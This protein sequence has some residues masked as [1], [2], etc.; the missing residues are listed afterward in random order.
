M[1]GGTLSAGFHPQLHAARPS[2]PLAGARPSRRAGRVANCQL[3]TANSKMSTLLIATDEAGYGPML[4]PL[5]VVATAWLLPD[6]C[7]AE[8]AIGALSAPLDLAG[9]GTVRVDDSKKVFKQSRGPHSTARPSIDWI[10]EA[11]AQWL[12]QP[13]PQADFTGWLQQTAAQDAAQLLATAWYKHEFP[14][15]EISV[16]TPLSEPLDTKRPVDAGE[17]HQR[18]IA[19][20]SSGGLRLVG[21]VARVLDAGPFN[22]WLDRVENKSNLL[23]EATCQLAVQ[24][25]Q[26]QAA[27]SLGAGEVNQVQI[28]SDRLGGRA[29][30]GGLLQHH[31]PSR[32]LQVISETPQQSSYR[33]ESDSAGVPPLVWHF[34]VSGDSFPPVAMSSVIAKSIRE[35]LM[36]RLNAFFRAAMVDRWPQAPQ[37]RPTAGYAV[38]A[39]RFLT[40]TERLRDQLGISDLELIRR[41]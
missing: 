14:A 13:D 29:Y 33:L 19:H 22:R 5:A 16:V 12:Q 24:L 4:G 6:D 40:D 31:L 26:A 21:Q 23:G 36:R 2:P 18:L 38:D 1:S 37:L 10:T 35:R 30:Y 27:G 17:I 20:W 15:A 32:M 11:A 8:A 28:H 41:K 3:P 39:R 25:L 9:L 7:D 34:T